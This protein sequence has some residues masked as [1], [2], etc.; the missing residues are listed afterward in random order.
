MCYETYERLLR[1]R[2]ARRAA[3]RPAKP[4]REAPKPEVR[5]TPAEPVTLEEAPTREKEP[6]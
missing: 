6:A 3:E 2:A 5:E 1:A 4:E